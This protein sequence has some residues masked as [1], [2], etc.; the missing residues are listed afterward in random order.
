MSFTEH[1]ESSNHSS[2]AAPVAEIDAEK[3]GEFDTFYSGHEPLTTSQVV[4]ALTSSCGAETT[5]LLEQFAELSGLHFMCVEATTGIVT[6]KT[7]Q[8]F[9]ALVP[10]DIRRSLTSVD[11]AWVKPLSSG[12]VFYALPV[13]S[14]PRNKQVALGYA[15]TRHGV[16]PHELV[17]AAV[18]QSWSQERLNA[19]MDEQRPVDP[20]FLKRMLKLVERSIGQERQERSLLTEIDDLSVQIEQTYE[21]ISLLHSL[22]MNL[23]LSRSPVELAE[24]CLDR[25]HVLIRSESNVVWIDGKNG[26]PK[27]L[28]G[29]QAPFDEAGLHRL[30]ARFDG[31]DWGRPLVKNYIQGT[32]LGADFPGLNNLTIVPI[33]EGAHRS[34][35]IASCN[36]SGDRE[37]GTVEANLLNSIATILGTHVRNIDLYQQH[38]E[39]LLSFVRSMVSTLDAKD[40][41][42]RGHSERVALVARRLGEELDLPQEDLED[43]YLSGVLH[44]IGKIGVDDWILRKPGKLTDDEFKQIQKHPMI[45]YNILKGLKNLQKIL[46]GVRHHHENYNGCGYPDQLAGENIPMM[47]RILAVADS[48]DAMGSDRPY[49]KGMPLERVEDIFRRGSGVQWDSRVIDAYFSAREDIQRIC[50]GYS[51]DT[52]FLAES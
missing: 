35:W 6:G 19:W 41:Y 29:G 32:L 5:K 42:T 3:S 10:S 17:L 36:L 30:I 49:R 21:E 28:V 44:D 18:E 48:Y 25:L 46:P 16:R 23:Q 40:P 45:G 13:P 2:L 7:S 33:A 4:A 12:L 27:F 47:A 38:E 26:A 15:F 37:F 1:S 8:D 31:H 50:D 43:I 51:L 39:L 9:L 34:G 14:E 22:T 52:G 11:G 24:L 20:I